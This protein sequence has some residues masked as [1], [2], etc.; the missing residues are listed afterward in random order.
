MHKIHILH[1]KDVNVKAPTA[2]W[3]PQT[4]TREMERAIAEVLPGVGIDTKDIISL[5]QATVRELENNLEKTRI[6]ASTLSNSVLCLLKL[7]ID[8]GF[9]MDGESVIFEKELVDKMKGGQVLLREDGFGNRHL[10]VTSKI[11]HPVSEG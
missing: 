9:S 8:H 5:Q 4:A 7:L 3:G 11:D 1:P 10:R 2:T 6:V